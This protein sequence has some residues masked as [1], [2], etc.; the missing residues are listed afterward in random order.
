VY[1]NLNQIDNA[2]KAIG[3][4]FDHSQGNPE[5][6]H[7]G[8]S[9]LAERGNW[10][11]L[12][13][14]LLNLYHNHNP[15]FTKDIYDR[16][17]EAAYLSTEH[18][19]SEKIIPIADIADVDPL[20][21]RVVEARYLFR[22]QDVVEAQ[23]I[24]DEIL[25][26]PNSTV[27][28]AQLLQIEISLKTGQRE[29]ARRNYLE[30][31]SREQAPAWILTYLGL[32]LNENLESSDIDIERPLDEAKDVWVHIDL[33]EGYLAEGDYSNA[34]RE[35]EIILSLA[36]DDPRIF[37]ATGDVFALHGIWNYATLFYLT[38]ID[39]I[40]TPS[41]ELM[42]KI[43]HGVYMS[44]GMADGYEVLM[45]ADVRLSPSLVNILQ[46]RHELNFGD[47]MSAGEL[48]QDMLEEEPALIQEHL[49]QAEF[50]IYSGDSESAI[51]ILNPIYE[52][53]TNPD[54][55]RTIAGDL[56]ANIKE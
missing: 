20:L 29:D 3:E 9:L 16:F 50:L 2:V 7:S 41:P 22:H 6:I 43:N 42:E 26:D 39:L 36:R 54:W 40:E 55:V 33:L 30:L 11:V 38:S 28:E 35:V 15:Y 32:V 31:Q 14:L 44:G 48:I 24:L 21:E 47:L 34:E 23:V 8:I 10:I 37:N 45:S 46:A 17:A 27:P 18:I 53:I 51:D 25:K 1:L 49:I 12:T 13:K 19:D 52:N 4:A 56:L 5:V